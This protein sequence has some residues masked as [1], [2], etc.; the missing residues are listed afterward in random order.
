LLD[1]PATFLDLRH[2]VDL[3]RLLCRL[4]KE[5]GVGVLMAS[6]DLNLAAATADRAILLDAGAVAADGPPDA[7][8]DAATLTRVYGVPMERVSPAGAASALVFPRF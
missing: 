4:A 2:Q 3:L 1:E 5:R 7:V 8:L 6:H